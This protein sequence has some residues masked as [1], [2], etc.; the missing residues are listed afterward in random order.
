MPGVMTVAALDINDTRWAN[1]NY[2]SCVDIYAPGVHV[3]SA[4]DTDDLATLTVSG[5]SS[6]AA[7]V[8]GVAAL[9]LQSNTT[10]DPSQVRPL[11]LCGPRADANADCCL[12]CGCC[13]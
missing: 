11:I 9:Y 1:S 3:T 7:H 8:T 4:T 12:Q 2:G 6:A 13:I 10:A 5:T